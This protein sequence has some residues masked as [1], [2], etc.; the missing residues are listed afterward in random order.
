MTAG[1]EVQHHLATAVDNKKNVAIYSLDMSA[2]FDLLRPHILDEILCNLNVDNYLRLFLMNFLSH[3]RAYVSMNESESCIFRVSTGVPQGSV[4]G[5]KLFSIYTKGIEQYLSGQYEDI[6]M[7]S[8][9]DDSYVICSA[10]DSKVLQRLVGTT[11]EN[12]INMLL[13]LGMIVN[14]SKTEI[15][16]MKGV[17]LDV[18]VNGVRLVQLKQLRVLGVIFDEGLTWEPQ[19]ER[20]ILG[21]QRLKPALHVLNGKLNRKQFRQVITSHYFST[22]YYGSEIWYPCLKK[23][24]RKRIATVH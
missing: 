14:T 4:L 16:V 7:V 15:M 18:I 12:H 5:P 9:A 17:K 3:R 11:M 24:V 13:N 6:K 21:C 1:L 19:A 22:L 2:A 20:S 10:V 8:Y 23:K